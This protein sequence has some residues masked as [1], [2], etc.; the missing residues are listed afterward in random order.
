MPRR[1]WTNDDFRAWTRACGLSS[2][3]AA[4]VLQVTE[5]TVKRMLADN[6]GIKDV[7]AL[8]AQEF[9]G[10]SRTT[11]GQDAELIDSYADQAD[12]AAICEAFPLA[13][14]SAL[15]SA[16]ARGWTIANSAD[17]R[18]LTRP[19]RMPSPGEWQGLRLQWFPANDLPWGVECRVD[20]A[21]RPYRIASAE[22]TLLELADREFYL[23]EQDVM[24]CY[25]GAF[26]LS[27]RR[28]DVLVIRQQAK[29]R[30]LDAA[31]RT[32]HYIKKWT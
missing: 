14:V 1:I 9:L 3:M 4:D 21:G 24:E 6:V 5:R 18:Q 27:E 2:P 20:T 26:A 13:H 12:F 23:G 29:L 8:R 15:S 22:R 17:I 25:A 28:P 16:I 19:V 31:E 30:G 7:I 32:Y 11:S 10:K